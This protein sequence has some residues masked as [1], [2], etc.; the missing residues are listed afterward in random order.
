M[1][2]WLAVTVDN[3]VPPLEDESVPVQPRIKVLL[4]IEPVTLVSF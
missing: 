4:E 3:P 2:N 1:S